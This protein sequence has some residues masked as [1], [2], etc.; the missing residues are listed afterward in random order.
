VT[1]LLA[2]SRLY[3]RFRKRAA[4]VRF[5]S[6]RLGFGVAQRAAA[7]AEEFSARRELSRGLLRSAAVAV[8]TILALWALQTWRFQ[9]LQFVHLD[10]GWLSKQAHRKLNGSSY[11]TTLQTLAEISGIFLALYLGFVSTVAATVYTAVPHDIRNLM[12]QDK[13]GNAYVKGVA[14]LT[15]VAGLLSIGRAAGSSAW[16]VALP[17]LAVLTLFAIYAFVRLGLRAFYF[18]DPSILATRVEFE[19]RR[20]AKRAT[21][22]RHPAD[23]PSFQNFYRA[24]AGEAVGSIGALLRISAL[25]G[26]LDLAPLERLTIS[27][28]RTLRYYVG[29]KHE[30]PAKSLWFGQ[31]LRHKQWFLAD[32]TELMIA[33]PTRSSL[34][35]QRVPDEDWVEEALFDSSREIL[36]AH[37]E[38][39]RYDAAAELLVNISRALEDVARAGNMRLAIHWTGL[40][41]RRAVEAALPEQPSDDLVEQRGVVAVLDTAISLLIA[42]EIGILKAIGGAAT[43]PLRTQMTSPDSILL[44]SRRHDFPARVRESLASFAEALEFERES[45]APVRTPPWFVTEAVLN[46]YALALEEQLRDLLP[47]ASSLTED[48]VD[49]ALTA[50][51]PVE[52]AAIAARSLELAGRIQRLYGEA[53]HFADGL[54][55]DA[56]LGDD[57]VRPRWDW[58]GY[59]S[60]LDKFEETIG[61]RLA[62]TIGPLAS[63]QPRE[64]I[65]DYLGQAVHQ[66]GEA[67]FDALEDAAEERFES[68]YRHYFIGALSVFERIRAQ[69]AESHPIASLPWLAQPVADLL[70]LSG[71]ALIF[72]ELHGKPEL[73]HPVKKAWDIFL[74]SPEGAVGMQIVA[75]LVSARESSF[76]IAPRD[77]VRSWD[78][79]FAGR[80]SDLPRA[81][82]E[83][84]FGEGVAQHESPLIVEL[85]RGSFGLLGRAGLDVFI[86]RYLLPHPLATGVSFT[87][88]ERRIERIRAL[89][90][91]RAEQ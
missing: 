26:N 54:A 33:I 9:I 53:E 10:H 63:L 15:A 57:I 34:L 11:D 67:C 72:A 82:S 29:I 40:L 46:S 4:W 22:T 83:N 88:V 7:V 87:G 60:Q 73:W 43:G 3:W 38:A 68:L 91:L 28:I 24:R 65:P 59:Q 17:V 44:V 5:R 55:A 23:D 49:Q 27:V 69:L 80:L 31:R 66:A 2:G 52:A 81:R 41:A 62:G 13:V 19:F 90:Q 21:G 89:F 48:L 84:V 12:I 78:A 74:S 8:L 86:A 39:K 30:I 76:G 18:F 14:L 61:E 32:S 16:V 75:A 47:W 85:A 36:D 20:W 37:L 35:P 58:P 51:R 25:Q 1:A 77:L 70:T 6:R 56:K 64:D 79:R 45:N 71:Y 42:V 50:K